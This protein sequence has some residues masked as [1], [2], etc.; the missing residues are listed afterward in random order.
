MLECPVFIDC[1]GDD[2][3]ES[4]HFGNKTDK[5]L[6]HPQLSI[7]SNK[8]GHGTS[9]KKGKNC[10]NRHNT[11]TVGIY[12]WSWSDIATFIY[13]RQSSLLCGHFSNQRRVSWYYA[14]RQ[15]HFV[16]AD[17]KDDG[18]AT[19]LEMSTRN[20]KFILVAKIACTMD[21]LLTSFTYT[22]VSGWITGNTNMRLLSYFF[23]V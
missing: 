7:F 12:H 9:Q 8:A 20:G 2:I 16:A 17:F 13:I 18:M 14:H 6:T 10:K 19:K 23:Q 11:T 22:S 3:D 15:D 4:N 5:K 21:R 1:K